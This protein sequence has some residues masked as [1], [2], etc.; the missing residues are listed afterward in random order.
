MIINKFV[1]ADSANPCLLYPD[2]TMHSN[3]DVTF[4]ILTYTT[5]EYRYDTHMEVHCEHRECWVEETQICGGVIL[6]NDDVTSII[7]RLV[8]PECLALLTQESVTSVRSVFI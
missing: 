3:S 2:Y 4:C 5:D 1:R 6:Q 8:F 7:L